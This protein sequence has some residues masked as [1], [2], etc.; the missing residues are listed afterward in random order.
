MSDSETVIAI[1][2][3]R[4]YDYYYEI[5]DEYVIQSGDNEQSNSYS[6]PPGHV[7][8]L[9]KRV[10]DNYLLTHEMNEYLKIIEVL[11]FCNDIITT[12]DIFDLVNV[13][14][15]NVLFTLIYNYGLTLSELE[16]GG[17][18]VKNILAHIST[19]KL[20]SGL[21]ECLIY[22]VYKNLVDI[23]GVASRTNSHDVRTLSVSSNGNDG[24]LSLTDSTAKSSVAMSVPGL[25]N[26]YNYISQWVF[27]KYK[28]RMFW[29]MPELYT[30]CVKLLRYNTILSEETCALI[31]QTLKYFVRNDLLIS[32]ISVPNT[33][34]IDFELIESL[35][36]LKNK[37]L[38]K[39][40]HWIKPLLKQYQQ[41]V[42]VVP[43]S[44]QKQTLVLIDGANWFYNPNVSNGKSSLLRDEIDGIG[45]PVWN[46]SIISRIR[47]QMR[48]QMAYEPSEYFIKNLRIVIVFN[49]RHKPFINQICEDLDQFI[50]YTPRGLNDDA[51]LLYLWL[52][53]PG[54]ILF[55]N[56]QY[57]DWANHVMGNHYLMGLWA[58]WSNTLKICK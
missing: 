45:T 24:T 54:A 1:N 49:E 35:N 27:A 58:H 50:I 43:E 42:P 31:S 57:N 40:I 3:Y 2:K 12:G 30:G 34:R 51:M 39:D 25:I 56:D 36:I 29:M 28:A 37:I 33:W 13:S 11:R 6:K 46:E 17:I 20:K 14:S 41:V 53:N 26:I 32:K 8:T 38:S 4:F 15:M 48:T 10:F 18:M 7:C 16:N 52:S 19:Q 9:V 21:L 47:T 44:G 5:R 22:I 55:S 23:T